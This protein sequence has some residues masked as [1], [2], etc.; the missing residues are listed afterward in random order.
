MLQIFVGGKCGPTF[1][2]ELLTLQINCSFSLNHIYTYICTHTYVCVYFV[3][4]QADF[5][6]PVILLLIIHFSIGT[7]LHDVRSQYAV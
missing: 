4:T 7:V 6:T 3:G 5:V 2:G 1:N